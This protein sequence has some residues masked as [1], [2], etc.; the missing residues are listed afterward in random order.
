MT[1]G[2]VPE[3]WRNAHRRAGDKGSQVLDEAQNAMKEEG[4][5]GFRGSLSDYEPA[6]ELCCI[7]L[8]TSQP[9]NPRECSGANHVA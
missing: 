7:A 2:V 6:D 3:D 9:S 5:E 8:A 1:T 4:L